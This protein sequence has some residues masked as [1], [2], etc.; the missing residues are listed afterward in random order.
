MKLD[1]TPAAA[2]TFDTTVIQ[3]V[4]LDATAR[5]EA[6]LARLAEAPT[7]LVLDNL[8]TPWEAAGEAVE[9]RLGALAAVPGTALLCSFRGQDAVLGVPWTLRHTVGQLSDTDAAALFRSVAPAIAPEDP[10]LAPLLAALGRVPLAIT[11]VARRAAP[12]GSLAALWEEWQ[13]VGTALAHWPGAETPRLGSIEHLI[14]F[15]LRSTRLPESGRRLFGLLGCLPAGM[16]AADIRALLGPASFAARTGLLAVGLAEER[17]GRLDLLPPVRDHALR[18]HAPEGADA[19]AWW[20][21]YLALA[22]DRGPLVGFRDGAGVPARLAPE[23]ANIDAA[24]RSVTAAGRAAEAATAAFALR[25]VLVFTG[26]GSLAAL[27]ELADACQ[28]AE[29]G[30]AEEESLACIGYVALYRVGPTAAHAALDRSRTLFQRA[31]DVHGEANCTER[32]GHTAVARSDHDA[33]GAPYE[34]ALPLYRQVGDVRRHR[35]GALAARR[36]ARGV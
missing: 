34:R 16:A 31:G 21:H 4:G 22:R 5:F 25:R 32:L 9:A 30:E 14:E 7:L 36:G 12:H 24:L 10:C 11:L 35:A 17:D 20:E 26:L 15:S 6:A 27:H 1:T 8:E 13:S 29:T 28:R 19:T 33:A 2:D 18:C 3:A 23:L